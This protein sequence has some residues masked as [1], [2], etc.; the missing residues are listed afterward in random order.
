MSVSHKHRF[1]DTSSFLEHL[2]FEEQCPMLDDP[3]S[4][5]RP[6]VGLHNDKIGGKQYGMEE[7]R[8]S[9]M[10]AATEAGQVLNV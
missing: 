8:R 2:G 4:L 10:M 9:L 6:C 7:E 3:T 1:F 5:I